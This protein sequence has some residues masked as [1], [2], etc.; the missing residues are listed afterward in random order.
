MLTPKE[1]AYVVDCEK[2][3]LP[4][5]TSSRETAALVRKLEKD[6][7]LVHAY[8]KKIEIQ[9]GEMRAAAAELR[10]DRDT[11]RAD[12][13]RVTRERDEALT[14]HPQTWACRAD[15]DHLRGLLVE[16]ESRE[17][18]LALRVEEYEFIFDHAFRTL[19]GIATMTFTVQA[20]DDARN[21]A[22][23]LADQ[24]SNGREEA[25]KEARMKHDA[26]SLRCADLTKALE[27][28]QQIVNNHI[29]EKLGDIRPDQLL[30]VNKYLSHDAAH[31]SALAK[32]MSDVV[33][34]AKAIRRHRRGESP[35]EIEILISNLVAALD[36]PS[37]K[38]DTRG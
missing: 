34:A 5:M 6:L 20:F 23:D 18:A 9:L 17:A 38:E 26:L 30:G 22:G 1:E 8:A 28:V 14:D 7:D 27:M 33:E 24:F 3:I 11:L 13:E 36:A 12:L 32:R 19:D 16:A 10:A 29:D 25:A 37:E 4:M 31:Y 2:S 15:R 21:L 35:V